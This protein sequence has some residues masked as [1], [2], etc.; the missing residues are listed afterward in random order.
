M[1]IYIAIV[2]VNDQRS[3]MGL[4][5]ASKHV[6]VSAPFPFQVPSNASAAPT[7]VPADGLPAAVAAVVRK[8]TSQLQAMDNHDQ[9]N[10]Y[11]FN[12]S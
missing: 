10:I 1:V 2:L 11:M 9:M 8:D 4:G 6:P 12:P 3:D 5:V 7:S